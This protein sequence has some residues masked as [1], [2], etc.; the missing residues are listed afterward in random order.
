M[1]YWQSY[2]YFDRIKEKLWM[3]FLFPEINNQEAAYFNNKISENNVASLH[4]R[5]GDYLTTE[6]RSVFGKGCNKTYYLKAIEIIK[7]RNPEAVFWGF[8][9]DIDY[10]KKMVDLKEIKWHNR[11]EL[12]EYPDWM[13]MYLMSLCRYNILANSSFSWWA[14]YLNRNSERLVIA[15]KEWYNLVQKDDICPKE[16][17]RL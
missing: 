1:G 5:G 11:A 9:N 4:I 14:A 13:D 15:P 2:K 12:K 7:K 6:N 17:I 8:T 10:A 16:W 3:D